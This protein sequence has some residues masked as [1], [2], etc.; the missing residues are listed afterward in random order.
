MPTVKKPRR[1]AW[2]P[3]RK[4]HEGRRRPNKVN[5]N[6]RGAFNPHRIAAYIAA[7]LLCAYGQQPDFLTTKFS[8][9][10]RGGHNAKSTAELMRDGTFR[11]DRHADRLTLPTVD[12]IPPPADFD[13]EH[14]EAWH[15]FCALLRANGML[16][17]A[18]RYAIRTFVEAERTAAHA[19]AILME[20]GFILD[21]RK[22]PAHLVYADAVKTMRAM[23][24]QF[25]LTP[26]ARL[27]LK[28]DK[29]PEPGE[30][31][32]EKLMREAGDC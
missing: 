13:V 25:G 16:T 12:A 22:H 31:L 5:G 20:E 23:F 8:T 21:G 29:P 18:D 14:A 30:S 28:A 19:Y 32:F 3:E 6:G 10:P 15:K 11:R 9:M 2:M 4:P 17:T 1:P 7:P 26:R 24:D 27:A